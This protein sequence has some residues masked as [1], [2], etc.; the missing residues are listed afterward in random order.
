MPRLQAL[1]ECVGQSLCEK[2]RKALQGQW[3]FA[4]VLPD[5][6]R[7]AF[8][9]A[10]KKLPGGDIRAALAD[11]AA[12]DPDEFARRVGELITEL[13]TTHSVPK[14]EL[15]AYLSALPVTVRQI[16]RRPSDPDG[17]TVPDGLVLYKPAEFGVF[18]PPR[19]PR[20][21][22]GDKPPGLIAI[23]TPANLFTGVL[24]CGLICL[25]NVWMDYRFLP[26]S[27]RSSKATILFSAIAGLVF[28]ALGLRGCWDHS[29]WTAFAVLA[30]ALAL[31]WL[32][33]WRIHRSIERRR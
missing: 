22:P 25:L 8:D 11:C 9:Y 2:G 28:L 18:L 19:A 1:L 4:D 27:L 14:A 16:L 23:L 15:A 7:A 13:A 5:V 12:V 31:G 24:G 32:S 20:F 30:G 21:R 10:H 29:G 26:Q 3:P 33:A 6:A 17:R